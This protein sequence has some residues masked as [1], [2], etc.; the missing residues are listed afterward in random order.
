MKR[1][2]LAGTAALTIIIIGAARLS[3]DDRPI[4][5][6]KM[7]T[8]SFTKIVPRWVSEVVPSSPPPV[9]A[10]GRDEAGKGEAKPLSHGDDP[11]SQGSGGSHDGSSGG[12]TGG[13]SGSGGDAGDSDS[14]GDGRKSSNSVEA[15]VGGIKDEVKQII[16]LIDHH[17]NTHIY[18]GFNTDKAREDADAAG[19]HFHQLGIPGTH[20]KLPISYSRIIGCLTADTIVATD[21]GPLELSRLF[22]SGEAWGRGEGCAVNRVD[23]RVVGADG[24]SHA[25]LGATRRLWEG[26][27]VVIDTGAREPLRATPNHEVLAGGRLVR[28]DALKAGDRLGERVVRAVTRERFRGNVYNLVVEGGAGFVAGGVGVGSLDRS[29]LPSE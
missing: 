5:K 6:P 10:P 3:A 29:F 28:A 1:A 26:E 9:D 8:E 20:I 23:A 15:V 16:P 12:S 27:L 17:V 22:A 18:F 2:L 7:G 4:P 11:G 13:S 19:G 14:G 25:V 24:A 21:R